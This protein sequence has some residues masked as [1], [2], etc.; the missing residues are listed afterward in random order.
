MFW[1]HHPQPKW[2]SVARN[3]SNVE[4]LTLAENAQLFHL[5]SVTMAD[6]TIATWDTKYDYSFWRPET[7]ILLGDTDGNNATAPDPTWQPLIA[8]PGLSRVLQRPQH[9]LGRGCQIARTLL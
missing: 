5:L 3:I 9:E 8:V 4:D 6:A 1:E 7:A 2:Y